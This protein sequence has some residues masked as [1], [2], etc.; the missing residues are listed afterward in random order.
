VAIGR[1]ASK[2]LA[3][4]ERRE[5]VLTWVALV[6]TLT[7]LTLSSLGAIDGVVEISKKREAGRDALVEWAANPG[8]EPDYQRLSLLYPRPN[9][10]VER[11]RLLVERHLSVFRR[12]PGS[13]MKN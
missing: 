13:T 2:R 4:L 11:G 12:L 8:A 9:V 6:F 3:K 5:K 10:V 1:R 7:A